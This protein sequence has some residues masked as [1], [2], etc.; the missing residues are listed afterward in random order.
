MARR[1]ADVALALAVVAGAT[2]DDP[3]STGPSF[4]EPAGLGPDLRGVRIGVP[5]NW[6]TEDIDP[7]VMAQFESALDVMVSLGAT[8]HAVHVDHAELGAIVSWTITVAEFASMREADLDRLE[9]VTQSAG[10][11]AIGGLALG[12]FDYLKAL[13]SRHL[14]QQGFERAFNEVDVIVTPGAPSIAPRF[15]VPVD[16]AFAGGDIA[17]LERIARNFLIGNVAGV[18]ALV[19]PAG[20]VEGMPVGL[21][22]IAPPHADDRC[23]RVAAAFQSATDH[24]LQLPNL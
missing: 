8:R 6:F 22:V 20:F 9:S 5:T 4:S 16:W 24:H 15:G 3:V 17:W 7:H 2:P 13:R 19:C 18:P 12:A 21:Q 1:A 10:Q 23:L 14:I 11:R